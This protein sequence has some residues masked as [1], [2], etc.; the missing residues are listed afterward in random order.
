MLFVPVSALLGDNV[1]DRSENTPWY[2][3]PALLHHLE[4]VEVASDRNFEDARFPVQWVVRPHPSE[5][6]DYRGYAGQVAGGVLTPGDEV[7]VL[8]SG[9]AHPRSRRSTPTT[10]SST[11]P[12]RR[13]RSP[14]CWRTTSTSAAAT[15]SCGADDA[16]EPV[17]ELTADVCWMAERAAARRARAT[18]SSTPT[19]TARAVVEEVEHRVDIHTLEPVEAASSA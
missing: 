1:V 15:C 9:L 13:C 18:R 10:A 12:T 4:H 16:P 7:V 2:Q 6:P 11:P 14:C 19:R 8:P 17:R 5:R 3:G